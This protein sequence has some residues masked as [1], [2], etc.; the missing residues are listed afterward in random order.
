MAYNLPLSFTVYRIQMFNSLFLRALQSYV[1]TTMSA[2]L[3]IIIIIIINIIIINIIFI[4][5][6]IIIII[7]KCTPY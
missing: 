6:I 5:F 3:L 2:Q 4:I 7:I 1:S